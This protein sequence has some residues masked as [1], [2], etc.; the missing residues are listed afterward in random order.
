MK[1]VFLTVFYFFVFMT[2]IVVN[3]SE[4]VEE[5]IRIL[6]VDNDPWALV[7]AAIPNLVAAHGVYLFWRN[8]RGATSIGMPGISEVQFDTMMFNHPKG[9]MPILAIGGALAMLG[10]LDATV[11][12][13]VARDLANAKWG[14]IILLALGNVVA[15][16]VA[17]LFE[18][19]RYVCAACFVGGIIWHFY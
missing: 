9:A 10:A 16:R 13:S 5:S 1:L 19:G 11:L 15:F 18:K 2:L 6:K 8:A 4:G 17:M 3:G 14:Q 12:V 7:L